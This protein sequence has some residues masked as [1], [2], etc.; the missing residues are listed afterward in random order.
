MEQRVKM[1]VSKK[2]EPGNQGEKCKLEAV[3]KKII[4][5]GEEI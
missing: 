2:R 1:N 3:R 5:E 4:R